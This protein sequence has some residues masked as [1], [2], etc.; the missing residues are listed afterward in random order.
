M[1]FSTLLVKPNHLPP[2]EAVPIPDDVAQVVATAVV[3]E[4]KLRR[5]PVLGWPTFGKGHVSEHCVGRHGLT[6]RHEC[7][8]Q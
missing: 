7:Q 4:G 2:R 5:L 6:Q 8:I 3:Q 1:R